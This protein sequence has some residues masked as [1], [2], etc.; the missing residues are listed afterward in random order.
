MAAAPN[1][2]L[3]VFMRTTWVEKSARLKMIIADK[4]KDTAS[5]VEDV[6]SKEETLPP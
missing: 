4:D 2:N 5:L 1:T 3:H 6:A